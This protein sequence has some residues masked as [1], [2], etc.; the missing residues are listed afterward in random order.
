MQVCT[1]EGKIAN[2]VLCRPFLI[3][4]ELPCHSD[5]LH[6]AQEQAPMQPAQLQQD[7]SAITS[8]KRSAGI[9]G[10]FI[11]RNNSSKS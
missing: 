11:R 5:S 10:E 3:P 9:I 7:T 8:S 6:S 1:K 4:L 2:Q